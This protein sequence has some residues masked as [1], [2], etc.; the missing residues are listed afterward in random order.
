MAKSFGKSFLSRS[1]IYTHNRQFFKRAQKFSFGVPHPVWSKRKYWNNLWICLEF[2]FL[3]FMVRMHVRTTKLHIC[4]KKVLKTPS[5][6]SKSSKSL[7]F[8]RVYC[9]LNEALKFAFIIWKA[10]LYYHLMKFEWA[11]FFSFS[12]TWL[13]VLSGLTFVSSF[14]TW[15]CGFAQV[16]IRAGLE[17]S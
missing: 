13:T 1:L 5:P 16:C 9:W 12:K 8:G 4:S 17:A 7:F 3:Y 6:S 11:S 14:V 2:V 10:V 15:V